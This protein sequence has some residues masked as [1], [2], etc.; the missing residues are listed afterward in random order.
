MG[1]IGLFLVVGI[2]CFAGVVM[3]ILL[4]EITKR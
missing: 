1:A 3:S 4:D 2:A